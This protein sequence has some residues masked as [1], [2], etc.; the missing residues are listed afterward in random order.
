[1]VENDGLTNTNREE[2]RAN[3]TPVR[4]DDKWRGQFAVGIDAGNP[5]GVS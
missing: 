2:K 1:M 4:P 5:A 3:L